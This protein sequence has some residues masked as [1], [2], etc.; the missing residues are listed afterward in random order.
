MSKKDNNLVS[1]FCM[2]FVLTGVRNFCL[3]ICLILPLL[4]PYHLAMFLRPIQKHRI[5]FLP[6]SHLH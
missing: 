5:I 6:F 4:D 2:D 3:F 1:F